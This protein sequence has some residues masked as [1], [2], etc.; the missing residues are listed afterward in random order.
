[1]SLV[2]PVLELT[3]VIRVIEIPP[4]PLLPRHSSTIE[5]ALQSALKEAGTLVSTAGE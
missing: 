5:Q 4:R 3:S 1:M 2:S